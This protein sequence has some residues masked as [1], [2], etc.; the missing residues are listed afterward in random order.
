MLELSKILVIVEPGSDAQPALDK[1][2][3]LAA[4]AESEL[5]LMISDYNDYLEDGFYFEPAQ[6]QKLRYEHSDTQLQELEALAEPL[7]ERGLQ[8]TLS[9]AWGNPP[10]AEIV[11]QVRESKPSL[12]VKSTRHHNPVSRLILS[13]ED[14]EL[15]RYCPAPLLL[16]KNQL[17]SQNPVFLAAVDLRHQFDKETELDK[18][19]ISSAKSL[20]AISGGAVQVLHSCWVPPLSG[21]YAL[22]IDKNK[23]ISRLHEIAVENGV[24]EGS[25][26]LS[27]RPIVQSL[28]E[29]AQELGVAAVVMGAVSRSRLDRVLI[30]NTAERVLDKLECDVLVVKPGKIPELSNLFL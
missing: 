22:D 14:W 28:P 16:V 9:T 23:E 26:A 18:K 6:A 13:N 3:Q 8:V 15:V 17:W 7:R 2:A 20:A 11:K 5:E 29:K 27:K 1:A 19:I 4:Y 24:G 12:V 10:Y 30:G 25:C 21:I